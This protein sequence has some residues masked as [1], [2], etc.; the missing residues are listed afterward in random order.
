[1]KAKVWIARNKCG[2]L[3]LFEDKPELDKD[4]FTTYTLSGHILL[5]K[6]S[7]PEITFENSPKQ[8]EI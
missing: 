2:T 3:S 4:V 5:N 1:M 6:D 8:I 7:H